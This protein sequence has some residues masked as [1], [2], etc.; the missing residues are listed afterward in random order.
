LATEP[1]NGAIARRCGDPTTR[2]RWDPHYGPLLGSDREGL[3]DGVFGE[4]DVT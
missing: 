3:G 1:V 4:I 2:V